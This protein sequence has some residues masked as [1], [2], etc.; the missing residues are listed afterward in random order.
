MRPARG[1]PLK[2][3]RKNTCAGGRSTETGPRHNLT[4]PPSS[5]ALASWFLP[6][7][8]LVFSQRHEFETS[9]RYPVM[10]PPYRDCNRED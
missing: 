6:D 4:L 1:P 2:K 10:N 5:T 7:V 8:L 9:P 3:L